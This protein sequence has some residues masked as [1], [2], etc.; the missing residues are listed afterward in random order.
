MIKGRL[1]LLPQGPFDTRGPLSIA[2]LHRLNVIFIVGGKIA[3]Y[4]SPHILNF[5]AGFP[6]NTWTVIPASTRI[7]LYIECFLINRNRNNLIKYLARS[8]SPCSIL[9]GS[10]GGGGAGIGVPH[11]A[12]QDVC[13]K[14]TAN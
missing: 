10:V 8:K 2:V 6:A 12:E 5:G 3:E 1:D 9:G 11:A 7:K 4:S 14:G 13:H